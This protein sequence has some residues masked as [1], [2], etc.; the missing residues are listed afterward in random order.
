MKIKDYHKFED[1]GQ[2][3]YYELKEKGLIENPNL[4]I[5]DNLCKEME[6]RGM[7][8]SGK[9]WKSKP[10]F[11]KRISLWDKVLKKYYEYANYTPWSLDFFAKSEFGEMKPLIP[12]YKTDLMQLE[13]LK[14]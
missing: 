1:Y 14:K 2:K 3:K 10:L 5:I 8:A 11:C 12:T 6:Y 7:D 13:M 4:V 9:E